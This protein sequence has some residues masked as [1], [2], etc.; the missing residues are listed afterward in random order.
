MD[1]L[2]TGSQF[3]GVAK[4]EADAIDPQQR[5]LLEVA[6][7]AAENGESIS[8]SCKPM[9]RQMA[10]LANSWNPDG[11]SPRLQDMCLCWL[12]CQGYVS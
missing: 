6:Y 2:L 1:L 3:F 9:D 8:R 7:E 4:T 10:D 5:I 12:V 11:G